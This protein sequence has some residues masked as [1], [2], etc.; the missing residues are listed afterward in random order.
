MAMEFKQITKAQYNADNENAHVLDLSPPV[1]Q[2]KLRPKPYTPPPKP[3]AISPMD[4]LKSELD[5][6]IMELFGD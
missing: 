4:D 1:E 2:P 6:T 5:K 3:A